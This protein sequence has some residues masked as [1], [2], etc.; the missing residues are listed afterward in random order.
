VSSETLGLGN[1]VDIF[2][3]LKYVPFDAENIRRLKIVAKQQHRILLKKYKEQLDTYEPGKIRGFTDA[4]IKVMKDSEQE[5]SKI[6]SLILEDHVLMSMADMF[7]AGSETDI[8]STLGTAPLQ[9][10]S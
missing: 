2:P 4:L 9:Q 3:A 10:L 1:L 8:N 6:K 7:A 5:D